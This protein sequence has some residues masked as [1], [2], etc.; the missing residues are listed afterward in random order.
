MIFSTGTSLS[1]KDVILFSQGLTGVLRQADE[2]F[3]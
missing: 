3:S 2:I 1:A